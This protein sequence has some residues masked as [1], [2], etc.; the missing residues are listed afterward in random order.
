VLRAQQRY[1]EA[2]F[3]YEAA[4]ALNRN[5]VH[6]YAHIGQCK[7]FSGLVDEAIPFIERAMRLSPRDPGIPMWYHRIG[8]VHL[9]Q[10]RIDEAIVWL[11]RARNAEPAQPI[12]RAW[13]ASAY[14]LKGGTERASV[15]L[16]EARRLSGDHRF[17]SIASLKALGPF[18]TP[19]FQALSEHTIFAGLRKAGMPEE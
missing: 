1:D 7:L 3:E 18:A 13:L 2:I 4:I 14:A 9:L 15:E 5:L 11:E 19:G 6:A 17:S 8:L 12:Y 16:A 10:S